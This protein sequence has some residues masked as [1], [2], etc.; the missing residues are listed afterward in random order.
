M[1]YV[2]ENFKKGVDL[3]PLIRKLEDVEL[4]SKEP[5]V[6]TGTGT[7]APTEITKKRYELELKNT[8][9]GQISWKKT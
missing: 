7:R 5:I 2:V 6:P 3:V 1:Q 4:S 9:I 8:W